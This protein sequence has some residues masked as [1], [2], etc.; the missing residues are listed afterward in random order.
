MNATYIKALAITNRMNQQS[1]TLNTAVSGAPSCCIPPM[2]MKYSFQNHPK[3]FSLNNSGV[4]QILHNISLSVAL[5]VA[6]N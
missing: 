4:L 2:V 3:N 5:A 1:V 6:L